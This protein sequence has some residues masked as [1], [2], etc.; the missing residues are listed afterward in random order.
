LN[1][2]EKSDNYKVTGFTSKYPPDFK[3]TVGLYA[4]KV[5]AATGIIGRISFSYNGGGNKDT[6][7]EASAD[8]GTTAAPDADNKKLDAVINT[9]RLS[10]PGASISRSGSDANFDEKITGRRKK[11]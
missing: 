7:V 5:Y 1:G 11:S 2:S 10:G 6:D 3:G 9:P 4:T 8:L